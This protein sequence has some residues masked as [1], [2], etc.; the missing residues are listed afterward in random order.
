MI[1]CVPE[2]L[3]SKEST[4]VDFGSNACEKNQL[5]LTQAV[6]SWL[7]HH[8]EIRP[9]VDGILIGASSISQ[10]E[11]SLHYIKFAE[12]LPSEVLEAIQSMQNS[13][14]PSYFRGFSGLPNSDSSGYSA[15]KADVTK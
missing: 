10:L 12:S 2:K 9:G 8:S 4:S 1:C 15:K 14:P 3:I 7:L 6:Y 11:E 5:S 13:D